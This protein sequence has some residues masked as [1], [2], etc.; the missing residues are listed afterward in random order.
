MVF[1]SNDKLHARIARLF[2]REDQEFVWGGDLKEEM[3]RLDAHYSALPP[4]V[5]EEGVMRFA[6]EPPDDTSFLTTRLVDRFLPG[7]RLRD[8]TKTPRES[9]AKLIKEV[10]EYAEAP[11]GEQVAV[12][13]A[14]FVLFERRVPVR[15]GKWR[16][17]PPGAE[18]NEFPPFR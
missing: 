8:K 1:T 10:R 13:D 7:W 3:R 15:M 2:L 6:S 17:L 14:D 4:D 18:K 12:D 16:I 9:A 5:L 11:P